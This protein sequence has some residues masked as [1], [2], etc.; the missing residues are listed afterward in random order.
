[1]Y[2]DMINK[3]TGSLIGA[4]AALPIIHNGGSKELVS[5]YEQ[6][7]R[8]LGMGFQIHDD[9]LEI[10]GDTKTMGK[11]LG[12]DIFEGKQTI[13]VIL[14]RESYRDEWRDLLNISD[15]NE[16]IKNIYTFFEAKNIIQETRSISDSYFKESLNYLK[17]IDGIRT[18]ELE[19]L[20]KLIEKRTY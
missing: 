20:V 7:G 12:S 4:S 13:M 1:M 8:N 10:T 15:T 17:K 14:A 18:E 11:S 6:F 5:I 19:Q 16:L 2:F 3:K 9:L